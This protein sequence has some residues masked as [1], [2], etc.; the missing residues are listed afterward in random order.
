[1]GRVHLFDYYEEALHTIAREGLAAYTRRVTRPYLTV[2]R[3][4]FD[5]ATS[6]YTG[7]L[8][9]RFRPGPSPAEAGHE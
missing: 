1:M 2:A 4:H 5:P 6:T 9:R 7:R 8:L 3:S